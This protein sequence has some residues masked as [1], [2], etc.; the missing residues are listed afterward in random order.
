M[1]TIE[2][3]LKETKTIAVVGLSD[4]PDRPSFGV[5]MYLQSQGYRIIPVNPNITQALGEK[6][7][8]D[9]TS[10]PEKIDLVDIFRRSA[11]VPPAVDEAIARLTLNPSPHDL[12]R[13]G[14]AM[15]RRSNEAPAIWMQLG[16]VNQAAADKATEAGLD[17]VMNH[18]AKIEHQ[19][20]RAEG[21]L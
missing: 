7:Y 15:A 20:L 13:D 6:A 5:A 3:I 4:K 16:I 14:K 11:D 18:C 12:E 10:V 19:K 1:R 9:L 21:K 17:V 2:Q 8:P